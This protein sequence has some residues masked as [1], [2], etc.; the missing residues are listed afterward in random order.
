M[1]SLFY[2]EKWFR[3][4]KVP[5]E[6]LSEAQAK[7]RHKKGALYTVLVG[8][9]TRPNSFLE[10]VGENAFVSV[11]FLDDELR[12][13]LTYAFQRVEDGRLFLSAVTRREY[14]PGTDKIAKA[15]LYYFNREGSVSVRLVD[16]EAKRE[17]TG[18][19]EIDV[20][21]NYEAWPEFGRYEHLLQRER[22]IV[23]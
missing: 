6:L 16:A 22:G 23:H 1:T 13:Y 10:V 12:D 7:A 2:C 9:E 18:S 19:R 17:Q 5:I 15:E 21:T 8:S 11:N 3:H 14:Q 4:D 20:A